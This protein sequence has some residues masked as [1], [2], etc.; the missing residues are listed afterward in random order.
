MFVCVVREEVGGTIPEGRL[1]HGQAIIL[2][3]S[4]SPFER[5]E[6]T[7]VDPTEIQTHGREEEDSS[8]SGTVSAQ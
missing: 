7:L 1:E 2:T 5:P 6:Q 4:Q 8:S 3:V